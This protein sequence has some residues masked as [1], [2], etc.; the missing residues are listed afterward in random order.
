VGPLTDAS[1][2]RGLALDKAYRLIVEEQSYHRGR[3]PLLAP[4]DD[5]AGGTI[6]PGTETGVV[7]QVD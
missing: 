7:D 1:P 2:G 4:L 3:V 5:A 6:P